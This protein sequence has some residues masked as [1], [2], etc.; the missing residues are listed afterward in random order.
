MKRWMIYGANGFIG[1]LIV[2]ECVRRGYQPI[3][4]GRD[5]E[6]LMYLADS[7]ELEYRVFNLQH[8]KIIKD[9]LADVALV[10]NCAGPFHDTAAPLRQAALASAC[11]YI[12]LSSEWDVNALSLNT[13]QDAREKGCVLLSGSGFYSVA[14]DVLVATLYEE[15]PDADSV[16]LEY[17]PQPYF[18]DGALKSFIRLFLLD[19]ESVK[20]IEEAFISA[21]IQACRY[22]SGIEHVNAQVKNKDSIKSVSRFFKFAAFF[23]P[24]LKIT[25][26]QSYFLRYLQ[27]NNTS[28][29]YQLSKDEQIKI[30][31][32]LFKLDYEKPLQERS[33]IIAEPYTYT[34]ISSLMA[35]THV[36]ADKVMPGA[37]SA[38]EILDHEAVMFLSADAQTDGEELIDIDVGE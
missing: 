20:N 17:S 31:A 7:S 24:L 27:K 9:Q 2:E 6:A 11:H 38:A 29:V 37:Y 23:L 16:V 1:R 30:S 26:L 25:W 12:D 14:A 22:S 33:I 13:F 5:D 3:L 8:Q 28:R 36:L 10:L 4:A 18:S 21:D 34:V 35:V 15:S 19:A 32:T